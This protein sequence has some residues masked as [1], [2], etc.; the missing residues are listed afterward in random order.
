ME[1]LGVRDS[2]KDYY[3]VLGL[4]R[5]SP[6]ADIRSAYR[7]LA[8]KWHP[9][10]RSGMTT[11]KGEAKRRFQQIQEA[12]QVLSDQR[13]RTLYDAGLYSPVEDE[14]DDQDDVEGFEGFLQE[15]VVLMSDVSRE[16]KVYSL[17]ELQRMLVDMAQD[18][19]YGDATQCPCAPASESPT[20]FSKRSRCDIT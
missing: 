19:N 8:M 1:G 5:G 2:H 20:R 11:V 17:E 16:R 7:K 14:D 6:S 13:K 18:F 15:M 4:R 10:R 3:A 12:Y 9:D